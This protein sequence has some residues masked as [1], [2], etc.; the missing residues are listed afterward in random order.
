M[1]QAAFQSMMARLIVEPDFRDAVRRG[2]VPLRDDFEP[3]D[4]SRLLRIAADPGLDV[5]RTLFKGFRLGKLR[6]LLPLTC[7][8]LEGLPL[9]RAVAAFWQSQPP[10]SFYFLPEAIEFCDH[11]L[12]TPTR[13][14]YLREVAA[15]ER[16]RLELERAGVDD[17]LPQRVEFEHEPTVLLTAL[18]EGRRPRAVPLRRCIV[19]GTR[20][21][22]GAIE[23]S[24]L[25]GQVSQA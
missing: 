20:D 25:D 16:A 3:R 21:A 15:F 19:M 6:S 2:D 24:L 8:L 23:W 4:R 5:N 10:T 22:A 17:P 9:Q 1:S 13:S 11:L 18:A 12:R 7:Q 14:R